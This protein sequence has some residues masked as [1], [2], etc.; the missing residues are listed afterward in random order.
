VY[1]LH[2]LNCIFN[3][4]TSLSVKFKLAYAY[5]ENLPTTQ[6]GWHCYTALNIKSTI[7]K[8]NKK[9]TRLEVSLFDQIWNLCTKESE[10][11]YVSGNW[12]RCRQTVGPHTVMSEQATFSDVNKWVMIPT[13]RTLN[14]KWPCNQTTG[15]MCTHDY[16][17]S[18]KQTAKQTNDM[19]VLH[20]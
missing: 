10:T 8:I 19:T 4:I 2:I 12:L 18:A 7:P 15:M 1:I 9:Y 3:Q 17:N 11:W 6:S 14:Y 16:I 20:S 13:R 5:S